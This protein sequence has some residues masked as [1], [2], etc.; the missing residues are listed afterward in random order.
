MSRPQF[1]VVVTAP[2]GLTACPFL[3]EFGLEGRGGNVEVLVV[4][5]GSE[6]IDCNRPG[7]SLIGAQNPAIQELI[8]AGLR[9]ARGEWVLVTEDHCRPLPGLLEAY[10]AATSGNL[11][12]DLFAGVAVNRTST[13]PWSEAVFLTGL[14]GQWA[15]GG[16]A[17]REPSNANMLI[18]RSALRPEEFRAGGLLNLAVPRLLA[19]K[20][21]A[22]C[23]E[24]VVDHVLPLSPRQAITFQFH[25]ARDC[26]D[27][28]LSLRLTESKPMSESRGPLHTALRIV[29][30]DPLRTVRK[31]PGSLSTKLATLLR[32]AVLGLVVMTALASA[33]LS[34][35]FSG[36][37]VQSNAHA[38]LTQ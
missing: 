25:C 20:R 34:R 13:S 26:H 23:P 28:G 14:R 6:P 8:A 32:L 5:P 4:H 31:V 19:A 24:A 9:A 11:R 21:F 35:R 29:A 12:V 22:A 18:R 27:A 10:R 36:A 15:E 37:P 38:R 1:S 7:F 16:E 30:L 2:N 17:I 3:D 33:R